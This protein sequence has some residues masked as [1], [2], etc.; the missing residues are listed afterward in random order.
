MI[1]K[2]YY[3]VSM[4]NTRT[5]FVSKNL[6]CKVVDLSLSKPG[7]ENFTEKYFRHIRVR[8]FCKIF[9]YRSKDLLL[10]LNTFS[11]PFL[12]SVH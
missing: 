10:K 9:Q 6:R 8:N 11:R 12:V 2:L 1:M 7:N 4:C 5:N 3:F